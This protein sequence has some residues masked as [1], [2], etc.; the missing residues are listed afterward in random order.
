MRIRRNVTLALVLLATVP[1]M[2]VMIW[3][4]VSQHGI[5]L[6]PNASHLLHSPS[7]T[8]REYSTVAVRLARIERHQLRRAPAATKA[9]EAS[10]LQHLRSALQSHRSVVEAVPVA[11][12]AAAAAAATAVPAAAAVAAAATA[13]ATAVPAAEAAVTVSAPQ[14][15][16]NVVNSG[17]SNQGP[18]PGPAKILVQVVDSAARGKTVQGGHID[19]VERVRLKVLVKTG[20]KNGQQRSNVRFNWVDKCNLGL[21]H[22]KRLNAE[23]G[24]VQYGRQ[25]S[26]LKDVYYNIPGHKYVGEGGRTILD[27]ACMFVTGRDANA[28]ENAR[29]QQEF[30]ENGDIMM[31]NFTDSYDVMTAKTVWMLQ[32]S[33]ETLQYDYVMLIDDDA[34][35]IWSN[36]VPLVLASARERLYCGHQHTTLGAKHCENDT[37]GEMLKKN[38]VSWKQYNKADYPPFASGFAYFVSRDVARVIVRSALLRLTTPGLPGNVEDAMV[39]VLAKDGGIDL[40]PSPRFVHY[41]HDNVP[42]ACR[43]Q[44]APAVF[45]NAEQYILNTLTS[46]GKNGQLLC[47]T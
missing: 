21:L 35:I 27:V 25:L 7:P 24:R 9:V 29:L 47:M 10:V 40:T 6:D 1:W 44:P 19:G 12:A 5:L 3:T 2:L 43:Q 26:L 16:E 28:A 30:D 17:H 33:V 13:A 45:G 34:T 4:T 23:H 36:F 31:G 38:C 37:K 41:G 42:R 18:S 8:W 20:P 15:S 32:W 39:G 22:R 14:G 11:A 46:K